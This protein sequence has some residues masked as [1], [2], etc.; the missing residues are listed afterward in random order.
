[1]VSIL[2]ETAFIEWGG[3]VSIFE[4]SSKFVFVYDLFGIRKTDGLSTELT[5]VI[6][7]LDA[8]WR[9]NLTKPR[10]RLKKYCFDA[11]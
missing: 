2:E 5:K 4:I 1:V 10:I 7:R 11:V 8:H 3:V 9:T 6:C